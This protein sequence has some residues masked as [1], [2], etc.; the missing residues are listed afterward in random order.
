MSQNQDRKLTYRSFLTK[1]LLYTDSFGLGFSIPIATAFILYYLDITPEQFRLFLGLVLTLTLV[2]VVMII[3]GIKTTLAPLRDY[4]RYFEKGETPPKNVYEKAYNLTNTLALRHAGENAIRWT[5]PLVIV[6]L[7]MNTYGGLILSDSFLIFGIALFTLLVNT[8]IFFASTDRLVYSFRKAGLFPEDTTQTISW[9]HTLR[10]V[11]IF[12]LGG[13]V[14]TL[15]IIV[16]LISYTS[17]VSSIRMSYQNQLINLGESNVQILDTYLHDRMELA[18]NLAKNPEVLAAAKTQ[19]WQDAQAILAKTHRSQETYYN[20]NIFLFAEGGNGNVRVSAIPDPD[21]KILG[22]EMKSYPLAVE[23]LEWSEA[24]K[25]VVTTSFVSPITGK[26]VVLIL[27]PVLDGRRVLAHLG[28]TYQVGNFLESILG[29][30]KIGDSGYTFLLDNKYNVVYHPKKEEQGKSY[31]ESAIGTMFARMPDNLLKPIEIDRAFYFTLKRTSSKYGY[32]LVFF[33]NSSSVESPAFHTTIQIGVVIFVGIALIGLYAMFILNTRLEPLSQ[34]NQVIQ[35]MR[36]GDL[37]VKVDIT[38]SDEVSELGKDINA[39]IAKF[40]EILESNQEVSEDMASSSEEMSAALTSLSSN[41]QTQAASAEEISA[42]IEEVSA[43]I[44]NVNRQAENQS[45]GVKV[46]RSK[47]ESMTQTIKEMGVQVREA[48]DRV[49]QIA[50]DGKNGETSLTT[51]K[52]SINK[53]SESSQEITS[54]VEIITSISEQIN[55]LA[56]NA[57]IEAARA[58]TYG[59]G[60]AV[61]A[62]EIGKLADKTAESIQEIDNLIQVNEIEIEQGTKIIAET[63]QLIQTILQGVNYFETM[64]RNIDRHM[65]SQLDINKA[66]NKEVDSLNEI[67]SAIKLAME[68]QKNAISEVAQAIYNINE[69]TQSTASGLEEMTAN[70]NGVSQM[71]DNL[72][73]KS[74]YFTV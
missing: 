46:L 30:T 6:P 12:L 31:R 16:S 26:V 1:Y 24:P 2:A 63:V 65:G 57:A 21:G 41:A 37:R 45:G 15:A 8:V 44:D 60:F 34:A 11:F 9:Y 69:L 58:G 27:T 56:L 10:F 59:K 18:E 3:I 23:Y 39:L 36:S 33:L 17:S 74:R 28:L 72:K 20:E 51:M 35:K 7:V 13:M 40:K 47:M 73:N 4:F 55:L 68:E 54:V 70:S 62:D 22:F 43:G 50:R 53:I 14:L 48:A 64:T 42:S 49:V 19:R 66:V 52:Q 25:S 61:V 71:A 38:N 5:F 67:T 29:R 32:R